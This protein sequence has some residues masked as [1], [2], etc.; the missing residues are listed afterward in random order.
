MC[1]PVSGTKTSTVSALTILN[2]THLLTAVPL[3]ALDDE[4][5]CR[6]T[7]W[8]A[9]VVEDAAGYIELDRALTAVE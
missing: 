6:S 8:C 1:N 3:H 5:G 4:L 2:R 7:V 9:A